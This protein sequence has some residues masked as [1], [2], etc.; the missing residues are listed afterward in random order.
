MTATYQIAA[1]PFPFP[2]ISELTTKNTALVIVDMQI[3]FCAEG[4]HDGGARSR[5]KLRAFHNRTTSTST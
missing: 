1:R 3:D 2:L 5:F 4:R